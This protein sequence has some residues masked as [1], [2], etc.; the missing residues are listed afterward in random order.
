[1]G[2]A[3]LMVVGVLVVIHEAGHFLAARLVGARVD[4]FSIGFGRRLWGFKRGNTD[5]RISLV[6]VGGYVRIPGLGPDESDVV[7]EGDEEE[8]ELLP[9]LQRVFILAAGPLANVVGAY[10]FYVLA[11]VV[12]IEVPAYQ[13]QA[14][15]VGYIDASSSVAGTDIRPGDRITTVDGIEVELWRDLEMLIATSGGRQVKIGLQRGTQ[16]LEVEVTPLEDSRYSFGYLDIVPALE[17]VVVRLSESSPAAKG[18]MQ[19][20]DRIVAIN[21]TAV[22]Q[23]WDVIN[24]VSPR[25]DQEIE[26]EVERDGK[27]LP[28]TVHTDKVTVGD[29]AEGRIGVPI[30]FESTILKLELRPATVTAAQELKRLTRETFRVLGKLITGRVSPKQLSGPIEIARI[31][32]EAAKSGP[33]RVI[34]FLAVISLQLGIFNLLPIPILDGGHLLIIGVEAAARRELSDSVKEKILIGGAVILVALLIMV[35]INDII[36]NI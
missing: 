20:G 6:P 16:N 35:F 33:R 4:V 26:I 18:G 36:K 1:M 23:F 11:F 12:G 17:P 5:Y 13:Y 3:F 30:I 2:L 9:K 32:G 15:V 22:E 14:P 31:S 19:L 28:L 7:G 21:G 24:L 27:V 8:I 25:P 29:K 34:W 10:L